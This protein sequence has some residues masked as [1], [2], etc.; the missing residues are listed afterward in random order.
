MMRATPKTVLMGTTGAVAASTGLLAL[1]SGYGTFL[2]QVVALASWEVVARATSSRFADQHDGAVWGT[3]VLING[4]LFSVPALLIY[5]LTR[6]KRRRLGVGLL[7]LWC[8]FYL[9][10]LFWLF[11]ASDGP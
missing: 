7:L 8:L 10:S 3:A 6:R 11:P 9:A 5:A 2:Y 4:L 1:V